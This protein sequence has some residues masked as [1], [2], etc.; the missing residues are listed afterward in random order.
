VSKGAYIIVIELGQALELKIPRF[1]G[2][3]LE[4]GIYA[5]CGSAYGP[6]GLEARVARHLKDHKA[7]HWHVDH[8]REAGQVTFAGV[9][10]GGSECDLVQQICQQPGASVP[11]DGFGSSD[12]SNCRAHLV[13]LADPFNPDKIDVV[14]FIK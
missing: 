13:L 9:K 8:L 12:C 5:Y 6:G 10:D 1:E 3:Y 7:K 11:I 4:P 14:P 2:Q